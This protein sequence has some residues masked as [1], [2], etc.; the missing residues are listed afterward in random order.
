[1]IELLP[2][3][4]SD[5]VFQIEKSKTDIL[6]FFNRVVRSF[7]L[8]TANYISKFSDD[9][10]L[11]SEERIIQRDAEFRKPFPDGMGFTSVSALGRIQNILNLSLQDVRR[12]SVFAF[13]HDTAPNGIQR[14]LLAL[15]YKQNIYGPSG[16]GSA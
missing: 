5:I 1:M 4:P 6:Q 7:I 11:F 13:E 3:F 10:M 14:T 2:E 16:T 8:N 9:I 15:P 12:L